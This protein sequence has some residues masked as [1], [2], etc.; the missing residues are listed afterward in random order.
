MNPKQNGINIAAALLWLTLAVLRIIALVDNWKLTI[1]ITKSNYYGGGDKAVYLSAAILETVAALGLIGAAIFLFMANGENYSKC[2]MAAG[3]SMIL[4]VATVIIYYIVKLKTASTLGDW[5]FDMIIV[6][7]IVSYAAFISSAQQAKKYERTNDARGWFVPAVVYLIGLAFCMVAVIATKQIN[8]IFYLSGSKGVVITVLVVEVLALF[9]TGLYFFMLSKRSYSGVVPAM[10]GV[11]APG[12]NSYAPFNRDL[13]NGQVQY[14]G[15]QPYRQPFQPAGY[16]NA[17]Y[18]QPYQPGADRQQ[19][20]YQQGGYQNQQAYQQGGYQNQQAYQQGGYQNQQAYQQGG[21]QNQQAYQQGGYRNQQAY[22]QGGYQNQQAYQQGG[23]QNQQPYQQGGYQN[24]Q[25][26][27]Q[28][29]YQDQQSY[30][31]GNYGMQNGFKDQQQYQQGGY[32]NQQSD[33]QEVDTGEAFLK[34][35][36]SNVTET[37]GDDNPGIQ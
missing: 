15:Q 10:R 2:I 3:V 25:A 7:G 18:R 23:Y 35:T 5:K 32:Q 4:E 24:Q 34:D 27:Q 11:P 9:C 1:E 36:V 33:H 22:Q 37:P 20:A 21:Y 17:Q 16:A 6:G 14:Q 29:G 31:Q 19:Q 30:Q 28:G 8:A 12:A 26:Y 13:V